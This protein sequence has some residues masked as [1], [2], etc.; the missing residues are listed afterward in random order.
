MK[1]T[2]LE[3]LRLDPKHWHLLLFYFAPTD[4]R[5]MVKKRFGIG[6]TL[7][8]ARPLAIPFLAGLIT[9]F[10]IGIDLLSRLDLSESAQWFVLFGLIVLTIGICSW[11]ANPRRHTDGPPS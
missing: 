4:P 5:I 6:W 10:Y 1:A 2:D 8:F 3:A 9:A 11:V 7:N